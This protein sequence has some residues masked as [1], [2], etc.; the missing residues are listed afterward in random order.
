MFSALPLLSRLSNQLNSLSTTTLSKFLCDL[1][2]ASRGTAFKA[3]VCD[4]T[5]G[6]SLGAV[7]QAQARKARTAQPKASDG[8]PGSPS[9]A[10]TR[11]AI[12]KSYTFPV[13]TSTKVLEVISSFQKNTRISDGD[14][15][16][17]FHLV[18]AAGN[19]A[20]ENEGQPDGDRLW[21]SLIL[22]GRLERAIVETFADKGREPV[23]DNV[24]MEIDKMGT[25]LR[26]KCEVWRGSCGR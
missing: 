3:A 1:P 6:H 14:F 16:V 22:D 26:M 15:V 7:Q 12:Q 17:L 9:K 5:L 8:A 13:P 2:T 25:I 11:S 10:A 23:E 24:K 20:S 18:V 4:K 19:L 21:T